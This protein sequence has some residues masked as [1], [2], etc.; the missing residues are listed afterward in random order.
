MI[1]EIAWWVELEIE[2]GQ[3]DKYCALTAEMVEFAQSEPGVL[4]YER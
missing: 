4:L 2:P 3:Y 1:K